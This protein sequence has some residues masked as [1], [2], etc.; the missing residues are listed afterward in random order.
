MVLRESGNLEMFCG[1]VLIWA[2]NTF[3]SRITGLLFKSYGGITLEGTFHSKWILQSSG[4]SDTY[5]LVLQNDGNLVLY[6]HSKDWKNLNG[7]A[8][9]LDTYGK[10]SNS[11]NFLLLKKVVIVTA[12]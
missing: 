7:I 8:A 6:S 4:D 5:L 11:K 10:C 1:K 2:S 12:R 3:D 9:A